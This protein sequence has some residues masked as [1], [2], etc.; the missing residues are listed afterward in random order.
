MQKWGDPPGLS[1]RVASIVVLTPVNDHKVSDFL[2]GNVA[3]LTPLV[4]KPPS[5]DAQVCCERFR[6]VKRPPFYQQN[7]GRGVRES[8]GSRTCTNHSE[9]RGLR[10]GDRHRRLATRD[11]VSSP[12]LGSLPTKYADLRGNLRASRFATVRPI[13]PGEDPIH[14]W[15]DTAQGP[16]PNSPSI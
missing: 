3:R 8:V 5:A 4:R 16:A 12:D 11:I 6:R 10:R 15:N 9:L 2:K 7:E 13:T 1:V 14:I